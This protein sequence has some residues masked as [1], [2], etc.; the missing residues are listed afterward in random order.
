[1]SP[2]D[3]PSDIPSNVSASND[4]S[5]GTR[6]LK[7]AI[8][9]DRS[10]TQNSD[11]VLRNGDGLH[12]LCEG[13]KIKFQVD[14]T[15][16]LSAS[17][18]NGQEFTVEIGRIG[19]ESVS[20]IADKNGN[21]I[22]HQTKGNVRFTKRFAA[23]DLS[24]ASTQFRLLKQSKDISCSSDVERQLR[25]ELA[26][27]SSLQIE[28]RLN[29]SDFFCDEKKLLISGQVEILSVPSRRLLKGSVTSTSTDVFESLKG[30]LNNDK[31]VDAE[32]RLLREGASYSIQD[33]RIIPCK[34]DAEKFS[35]HE[36]S[37]AEFNEHVEEDVD[38][39]IKNGGGRELKQMNNED[40]RKSTKGGLLKSQSGFEEIMNELRREKEEERKQH[41]IE[42]EEERKEHEAE[43]NALTQ[44]MQ[45]EQEEIRA[46]TEQ[47]L[48][49]NGGGSEINNAF[50]MQM[51]VLVLGCAVAGFSVYFFAVGR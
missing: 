9:S 48:Q 37:N 3:I 7:D 26:R 5:T 45:M 35:V 18:I 32:Q 41:E 46:L 14:Y 16:G 33:V 39:D 36:N 15:S 34:E 51:L 29:I 44:Q 47:M 25:S 50:V 6:V 23:I 28:D 19:G 20:Y 17:Q 22:D 10:L 31:S 38:I 8:S 42:K 30:A 21:P 2:S 24:R 40:K 1:M 12:V 43:I 11:F 27:F 13:R 49:R 4:D